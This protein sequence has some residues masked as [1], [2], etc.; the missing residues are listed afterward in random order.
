[1]KCL[2]AISILLT[3]VFQ[4]SL[5]FAYEPDTSKTIIDTLPPA[6]GVILEESRQDG[7]H[8]VSSINF[9][10]DSVYSNYP[11]TLPFPEWNTKD[12]H[13]RKFDFS[14]SKDSLY[15][16][17]TDSLGKYTHPIKNKVVSEFDTRKYRFHYGV[18]ID[19]NTGDTILCS[20]NGKVRISTYSKTYGHVVVVRHDNGLETIYAH[21]SKRFVEKDSTLYSGE[22]IGLGGNTGRSYGSHL[23]YE[24]R[25]FDEAM[26]PRDVID[27][28][29]F[30]LLNDTLC[31]SQ[32]NFAYREIIKEFSKMQYHTIRSGNTLSHIAVQYGTTV[33]TLCQLN[34]IS[35][36]KILQIGHKIRVR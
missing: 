1:M 35:R 30:Q 36:N 7:I 10:H 16:V 21:L 31:I 5:L 33:N 20:F 15:I 11:D 3:A 22:I 26:N 4:H 12:I 8:Y 25:Y 14:E 29:N 18:D 23:H 19:L 9:F 2:I 17:L 28:E 6:G 27:F 24:I 34:G 32:C 13:C